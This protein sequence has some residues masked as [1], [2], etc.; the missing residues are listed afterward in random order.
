MSNA[1][2]EENYE[3]LYD[4][5]KALIEDERD[6]IANLANVSALLFNHLDN[7]NWAGFYLMKEGELVLGPFQGNPACIRIEVGSGVCGSAVEDGKTYVVDNVHQFAGHIACD[8]A[9]N[10]EIVVPLFYE[11]KIVGVLDID[12]PLKSNFDEVDKKYLEKMV[13]HLIIDSEVETY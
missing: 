13:K 4:S 1:Q 9:S 7:V 5:M 12:S 11:D 6:W 3:M 8:A 10:S 2:K